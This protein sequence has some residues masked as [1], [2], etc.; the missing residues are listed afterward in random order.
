LPKAQELTPTPPPPR[1]LRTVAGARLALARL[2]HRV[3]SG[4]VDPTVGRALTHILSVLLA[5]ARD[6][7]FEDRLTVLEAS[8]TGPVMHAGCSHPG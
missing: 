3:D 5:S 6:H 2:Y 1:A 8:L 7:Q 4:E